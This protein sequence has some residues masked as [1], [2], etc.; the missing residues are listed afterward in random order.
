MSAGVRAAV[1]PI[2]RVI[3]RTDIIGEVTAVLPDLPASP[4]RFVIYAHVGQHGEAT[5]GWYQTTRPALV[6][7]YAA[8]LVELRQIYYEDTL[9]IAQRLPN[10]VGT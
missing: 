10:T 6:H 3:F 9:E 5:R 2:L 4:G 8:L 1:P 7:E